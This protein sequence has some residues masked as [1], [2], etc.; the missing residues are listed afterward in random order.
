MIFKASPWF[1]FVGRQCP[2][3]GEPPYS[4]AGD[5]KC[6]S[7][8]IHSRVIMWSSTIVGNVVRALGIN[9]TLYSLGLAHFAITNA[10]QRSF[11][12][13]SRFVILLCG[14]GSL[15]TTSLHAPYYDDATTSWVVPCIDDPRLPMRLIKQHH[16]IEGAWFGQ[17]WTNGPSHIKIVVSKSITGWHKSRTFRPHIRVILGGD[18]N[19]VIFANLLATFMCICVGECP[20]FGRFSTS[21]IGNMVTN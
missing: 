3:Y 20:T 4:W 15:S 16:I 6:S 2:C 19:V 10:L 7:R 5:A 21:C 18:L 1:W 13:T 8:A 12:L 17:D 14:E 9:H 11:N